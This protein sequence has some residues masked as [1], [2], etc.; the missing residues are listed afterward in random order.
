MS[1]L[2][3]AKLIK[4]T[5]TIVRP[6]KN[7]HESSLTM[8]KASQKKKTFS[9]GVCRL[10]G[11]AF[12]EVIQTN[13]SNLSC[14]DSSTSRAKVSLGYFPYLQSYRRSFTKF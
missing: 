9:V 3:S 12:C 5:V 6:D 11:M 8:L 1:A 10:P 4:Y 2:Q 14:L 7:S 13:G